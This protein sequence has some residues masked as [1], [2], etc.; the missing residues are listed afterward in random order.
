MNTLNLEIRAPDHY[1]VAHS[2]DPQFGEAKV[3]GKVI[4]TSW[5]QIPQ[6]QI[7]VV[8][9]WTTVCSL[10]LLN[11]YPLESGSDLVFRYFTSPKSV[12]QH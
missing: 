9:N 5:S 2:D 4:L 6:L 10:E 1:K 8:V 11:K 3:M 12:S 7:T